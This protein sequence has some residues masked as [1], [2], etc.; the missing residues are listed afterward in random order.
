MTKI[1]SFGYMSG[2][3]LCRSIIHIDSYISREEY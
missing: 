2:V 3:D 1:T